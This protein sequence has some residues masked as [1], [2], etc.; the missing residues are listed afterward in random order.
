MLPSGRSKS[1]VRKLF[2]NS[3]YSDSYTFSVLNSPE[4]NRF[5][6]LF[7]ETK[8]TILVYWVVLLSCL[9]LSP[10]PNTNGSP[11]TVF[12]VPPE[13]LWVSLCAW[14]PFAGQVGTRGIFQSTAEP[15]KKKTKRKKFFLPKDRC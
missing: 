5:Y 11:R 14:T 15:I 8:S 2:P 1:K 12:F 9:H 13:F 6:F 7:K 4:C 3:K 10:M